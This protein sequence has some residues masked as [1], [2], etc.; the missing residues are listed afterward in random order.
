MARAAWSDLARGAWDEAKRAFRALCERDG[1]D[2]AGRLF[3]SPF[4]KG[5]SAL[6]RTARVHGLEIDGGSVAA[7]LVD[8]T[9]SAREISAWAVGLNWSL[10]RNIKQVADFERTTFEG[11]TAG[12]KDRAAENV[13]FIRTQL[14]F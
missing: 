8:V 4:K 6:E 11:G 3:L 14:S 10:T 1:K 5:K 13:F 7:G 9:K 2:L 12:G